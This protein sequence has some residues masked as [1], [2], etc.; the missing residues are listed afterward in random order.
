MKLIMK[1]NIFKTILLMGI[2]FAVIISCSK[3]YLETQPQSSVSPEVVFESVANAKTAVNGISKMMTTQYL[4]TQGMNGEGT[5]KSWYA[6]FTGNDFQKCNQTGWAPLW[7]STYQERA[8]SSYD[9]YPWFYYYKLI[10]NANQII[11]NIDNA[12]GTSDER[13]FIKG[14]GLVYRA[15]SFLMLSQLY[16]HRW[17]DSNNGADPGIVLRI[18][19]S[20]GEQALATLAET[21]QQIY[22]DL[23]EAIR[24]FGESGLTREELYTEFNKGI[25]QNYVGNIFHLPDLS[26]AYA[27]YARAALTRND[28]AT[29]AKMAPL[30][31][32]G[33]NLMSS[34]QYNSGFNY[35]N[36]EW[37]WGVYET[38]DQTLYYYSFYAYQGSNASSSNCRSYPCAISKEL[39]DQIPV[40]DS[41]RNLW[42]EPTA[43]EY[44][45]KNLSK[46][47]GRSTG[48]L[49]T[50][51][52]KEFASKIYSTSYIFMYMQFKHLAS[53]MPGG[54]CFNI[55]RS[56]EMYL[57][58][59]EAL[60]MMGGRD[61]EVQALLN[62]LNKNH[63]AAYSC[64]KTGPDLLEEVKLYRRIDLWG[65]GFDWFDYKRWKQP[66]VRKSIKDGGSFHATY[67]ITLKPEDA[68][69]WTWVI[70]NKEKD[71]NKLIK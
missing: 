43:E 15:Y 25:Y 47:T 53:F 2:G 56:A 10:G 38:E 39:Y 12:E 48:L 57:I 50:R 42:L 71:Y 44:A 70:P 33:H 32:K 3:D 58:E 63:D 7:N 24:L 14:Q 22:A 55:F 40:T 61:A 67:A 36:N 23:D 52:R 66:I 59:A 8:T 60:C 20:K 6:N 16:C 11:E 68:N 5:I 64:T 46:T 9:Y 21:Y 35:P 31:R 26:V 30:A 37:I 17:V 29:A 1:K 18:D 62:E 69:N 49:Q 28:W 13:A 41:R 4:G 54:G 27:V 45:D 19:T 34:E 51:A 65:E